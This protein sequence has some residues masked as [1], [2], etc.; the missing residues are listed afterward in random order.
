VWFCQANL[1]P[2]ESASYGFNPILNYKKFGLIKKWP[3]TVA[4]GDAGVND[5][6]NPILSTHMYPP[7]AKPGQ[8]LPPGPPATSSAPAADK[9]GRP[10]P[11]HPDHAV[12][13][14]FVDGHVES[15][16]MNANSR[17]Y[18]GEPGD[19]TGNNVGDMNHPDY[20]DTLWDLN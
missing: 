8:A 16:R 20:K 12:N 7:S 4:I 18:P 6:R 13:V 1:L 11:R 17:F 3:E 14:G 10:N 15:L 5:L 19:W 2:E 9:I